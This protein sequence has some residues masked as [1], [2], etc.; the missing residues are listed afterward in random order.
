MGLFKGLAKFTV[1]A[2]V[3]GGVCYAFKGQIKESSIYKDYDVDGKIKKAKKI[4][5]DNIPSKKSE[6]TGEAEAEDRDYV[7]ITPEEGESE[8]TITDG[9]A[10]EGD[11]A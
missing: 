11:P 6:E 10:P 9:D 7:S 3:V 8:V 2:A 5:K 1:A 4:I